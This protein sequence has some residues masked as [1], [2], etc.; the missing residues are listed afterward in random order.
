MKNK[1]AKTIL[2]TQH[3]SIG[4]E[5]K[6]VAQNIELNIK[7]GELLAVIGVNGSGKSTLLKTIIKELTPIAGNVFLEEVAIENISAK[8]ISEKISI[9]L[10][11]THFSKNLRVEELVSLGRQPYSNWLGILT[12]KDK[13]AVQNALNLIAVQDLAHKKCS[14]LSDGQLQK[15]M[16][17]RALA[18]NT[19]LI[20]LD[21]P[22]THLDLYHKAFVLKML[23][24]LSKTTQKAI[25]FATHEIDLALQLCD[26]IILVNN[27]EVIQQ[28]PENLIKEKH[29]ENLFPSDLI[30]FDSISKSFKIKS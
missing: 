16:L 14:D 21:E 17:A 7:K 11:E 25:V 19:P 5:D 4:Y 2:S 28:T 23:K 10:T 9:V 30:Q 6:V 18:Q 26:K 3:L 15:V 22:T 8:E 12:S 13:V 27:G 1:E 20:M 24:K 29:L